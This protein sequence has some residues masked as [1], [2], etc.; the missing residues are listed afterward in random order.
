MAC[1]D[2]WKSTHNFTKANA[3]EQW[4]FSHFPYNEQTL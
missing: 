1:F 2:L 4:L 3:A